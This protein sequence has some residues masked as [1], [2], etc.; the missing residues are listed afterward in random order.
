M[1]LLTEKSRSQH[2]TREIKV[3]FSGWWECIEF[4]SILDFFPIDFFFLKINLIKFNQR[5]DINK[6]Q[7]LE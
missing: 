4:L 7:Y 6:I 5:K 1:T 2:I 3:V